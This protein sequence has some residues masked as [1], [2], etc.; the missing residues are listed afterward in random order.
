[1]LGMICRQWL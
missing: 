1:L